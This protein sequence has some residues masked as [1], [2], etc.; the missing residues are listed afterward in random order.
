M[1]MQLGNL[2][3]SDKA[4]T[5]LLINSFANIPCAFIL[6]GT[7]LSTGDRNAAMDKPDIGFTV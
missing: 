1:K 6:S 4:T 2:F 3:C 5:L 7:V